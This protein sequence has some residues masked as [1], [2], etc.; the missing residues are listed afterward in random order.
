MSYSVRKLVAANKTVTTAGT[1][2]ALSATSKLVPK[3]LIKALLSNTNNVYIGDST[4]SATVGYPLDAGE[5]IELSEI[6]GSEGDNMF[7]L[8]QIYVDSDTDGEGVA[9]VYAE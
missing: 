4:T 8:N 3:L 5:E 6:L 7:D 9:I 1:A 2:E